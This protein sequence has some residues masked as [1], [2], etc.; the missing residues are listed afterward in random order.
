[1]KPSS[2]RCAPTTADPYLTNANVTVWRLFVTSY[3]L[4]DANE[5]KKW[6]EEGQRRFPDDYRFAECQVWYLRP[7]GREAGRAGGVGRAR[8]VR[9]PEPGQP[10][11][12]STSCRGR[13]GW[14]W[15]WR[16][17][18]WRTAPAG[19]RNGRAR[20]DRSIPGRDLAQIEAIALDILGDKDGAFKQISIWLA[21][22]PQQAGALDQDDT[23]ELKD[24]R[25]DPRLLGHLQREEV[26]P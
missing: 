15:L 11:T 5:A 10:A 18:A 22:N 26:E 24:L 20:T 4:D 19:W 12:R 8:H 2:P 9:E 16:A 6:C 23:W 13:C 17:R 7:Q 14:P 3:Q 25:D 21:S 1:M